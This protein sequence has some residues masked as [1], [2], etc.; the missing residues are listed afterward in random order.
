MLSNNNLPNWCII[1]LVDKF[2]I[3]LLMWLKYLDNFIHSLLALTIMIYVRN[4]ML[5]FYY[6]LPSNIILVYYMIELLCNSLVLNPSHKSSILIFILLLPVDTL[7]YDKI[8]FQVL[9]KYRTYF[10][11]HL[12]MYKCLTMN[13]SFVML[14]LFYIFLLLNLQH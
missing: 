5:Y 9:N 14:P 2:L 1:Y 6:Q 4:I 12:L 13:Y 7:S 10:K 8:S 11:H 3:Y